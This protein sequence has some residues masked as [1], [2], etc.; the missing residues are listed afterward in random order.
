LLGVTASGS[1]L[2]NPSLASAK[3]DRIRA[4]TAALEA[5]NA[6]EQQ[7][8]QF[9]IQRQQVQLEQDLK[10]RER[11]AQLWE[12]TVSYTVLVL[13]FA[14]LI[15]ACGGAACLICLGIAR[16][17]ASAISV[18]TSSLPQASVLRFP[19]ERIPTGSSR[20]EDRQPKSAA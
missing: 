16:L 15:L 2:L 10:W 9:E 19:V 1:E 17:K 12:D 6:S 4:E 8:L 11:R 18:P 3:A 13:Q 5:K 7:R 20:P 14:I